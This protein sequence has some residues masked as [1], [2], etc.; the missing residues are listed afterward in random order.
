MFILW[1]CYF[2]I[3]NR[4]FKL[5][6]STKD[7]FLFRIKSEIKHHFF[8]ICILIWSIKSS[9]CPFTSHQYLQHMSTI[10]KHLV[11]WNW[12]QTHE[13][14]HRHSNSAYN[15]YKLKQLKRTHLENDKTEPTFTSSINFRK[16]KHAVSPRDPKLQQLQR[17]VCQ[18]ALPYKLTHIFLPIV[19][20]GYV[21]NV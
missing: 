18:G 3:C 5:I 16:T 19:S 10:N 13:F 6:N 12:Q 8:I 7:Q 15:F 2:K 1:I 9:L 14:K 21:P 4:K 20:P 17:L 11:S